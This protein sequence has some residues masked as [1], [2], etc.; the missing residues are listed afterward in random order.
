MIANKFSY[1]GIYELCKIHYEDIISRKKLDYILE[2]RKVRFID[3]IGLFGYTEFGNFYFDGSGVMLLI[4]ND[5]KYTPYHKPDQMSNTLWSTVPVIFAGVDTKF[6]D[7]RMQNI[8][9]GDVVSYKGY[10]SFVRHLS[11]TNIPGLAGDNAEILFEQGGD[12]HKEGTVFTD[13]SKNLYETFD[14]YSLYWPMEQFYPY[15]I[16]RNDV[17]AKARQSLESPTFIDG[18]PEIK[19]RRSLMYNK[20]YE[21]TDNIVKEEDI[22]VNFA[23]DYF[24]D[25]VYEEMVCE[26]F[27][28]DFTKC[29]NNE[30]ICI[31]L[32]EDDWDCEEIKKIINDFALKAHRHPD[33]YYIF[34][35]FVESLNI[36]QRNYEK[37]AMAFG[38]CYEYKIHNLILP[39]WIMCHIIAIDG[40]G[41]D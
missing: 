22:L 12:F 27:D 14:I 13:I 30:R 40:I 9:T 31:T 20:E 23:T 41:R 7:N 17:I 29:S 10:T 26:I 5:L 34:C 1:Q 21:K 24:F 11:S 32:P 35:D 8:F 28:D 19:K 36:S 33:T 37:Y 39:S 4:T 2:H 25:D 6:K 15:G 38:D 3:P 18:N 16:S